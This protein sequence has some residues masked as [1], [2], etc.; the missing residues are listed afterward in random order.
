MIYARLSLMMFLQFF[1]W[2]CWFVTMGSFL[3]A[4]FQATGAQSALAYSTQSWG[5]IIAPFIIGL[6]ADRYFNAERILGV[7][8][9]VGAALMYMMFKAENFTQFYPYVLGYMI[10]YMPTL[11]LV[12]SISFRQLTDP[13]KQ[14]SFVRVWGTAGWIVA[15]L[16]ISLVFKWDAADAASQGA[17]RN[18]FMMGSVTSALLALFSFTLPATPPTV[19]RSSGFS[20]R[21]ALGLDALK[22]LRDRNFLV[23]F[24]SSVLICI[25]LAFYYQ[26]ASLFLTE[27]GTTN[28]T[29]K[30]SIGQMSEV[31]FMLLLPVFLLRFGIKTTL[32]VGMLAWAVRYVLFAYGGQDNI[33]VLLITGIA[34]HGI[35]YDFFFVSGQ[36]FTDSKAGEH[37]RSAAQGMITLA[38]YGVGM[39]IGFSVAGAVSDHFNVNGQHDWFRIWLYP[40][41]FAAAVM[42]LFALLFRRESISYDRAR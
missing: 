34:L 23:F 42:V 10:A 20:M 15:G 27:I 7:L 8:H 12:N 25:P 37:Y 16:L 39:L 9:L 11:A 14:F 40:A 29:G 5:A 19:D 26:N 28:S 30:L 17:L 2:G 4:N 24:I 36:I 35:C 31:L 13:S 22:L 1:I 32:L 3:G 38:T 6:I 41:A 33:T 21:A 18:T